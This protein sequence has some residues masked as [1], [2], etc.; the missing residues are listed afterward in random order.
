MRPS[1]SNSIPSQDRWF[2]RLEE[3]ARIRD[4]AERLGLELLL[5][6]FD[7]DSLDMVR[8]LRLKR[9]KVIIISTIVSITAIPLFR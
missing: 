4:E 6:P 5:A 2:P 7:P 8:S 9:I 1:Q 3:W